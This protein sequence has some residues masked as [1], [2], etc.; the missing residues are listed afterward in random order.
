MKTEK[1][2]EILGEGGGICIYRQ[3]SEN[4]VIFLYSHSEFD[5][6]DEGLDF[7]EKAVYNSFEKPFQL[8]N[9][10]YSWYKLYIEAIHE[11]YKNYI[12]ENLIEILNKKSILPDHLIFNKDQLEHVLNIKLKCKL[13]NNKP[14]WTYKKIDEKGFTAQNIV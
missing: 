11:D 14:F 8:I 2:F 4:E 12:T 9:N 5:P 3:K 6:T 7:N 10:R 1:V 13:I